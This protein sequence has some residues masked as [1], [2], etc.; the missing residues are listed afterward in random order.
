MSIKSLLNNKVVKAGSWYTL[1]EFF[2]KG[3]TF[4]TIP[5]F[6]RLLSPSD[7]GTASL[8]LTWV[9]I[10]TIIIGLCLNTSITKGKYDFKDN[11]NAFVSSTMFLSVIIFIIYLVIFTVFNDVLLNITGLTKGL[12]YFML[13][14]AYFIFVRTSIIAKLRVEYKYKLISLISILTNIL[15]VLLSIYLILNVYQD[16]R[17]MGQI[18]GNGSLIILIGVLFLGYL[19][20]N[21]KRIL[22]DINY[23]KY[24]L[25]LSLPLVLA[26]LSGI[27]N[28]QFDR[29]VIDKY[30][31]ESAT[32]LYS[33]AYNVG[34]IISVLIHALDQAWTPWVYE[35]MEREEYDKIK[36]RGK[37]YRNLITLFYICILLISPEI[38]RI[39][40]NS[41]Y[42]DSL[43]IVPFI[44]M[45]YYFTFMYTLEVKTEFHYRKT[46]L[47]SLGTMLSAGINIVLNIIFVP[48][49]GA[50]AAAITTTISYLFLFI[51]H[52]I[53]TSRI[54]KHSVYGLKFHMVSIC[55]VIMG[56]AYYYIFKDILLMRIVGAIIVLFAFYK[57]VMKNDRILVKGKG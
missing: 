24:A 13:L 45:G 55:Q 22:I 1:T 44:F 47:I 48:L 11:Y 9:N 31:G 37:A 57:G 43:E 51:F 6:T 29:I 21:G 42:W 40:A 56:T 41:N 54:I 35:S 7:Y 23:W 38:I 32:G 14:H 3:I 20:L 15:G 10:F 49:Y 30:I 8:Y 18:I 39:M 27:A 50:V 16:K 52:Y 46:S 25:G 36:L 26:S 12:F 28:A 19:I 17:Y 33:F 53:I 4:L 5:I 2:L 34:M